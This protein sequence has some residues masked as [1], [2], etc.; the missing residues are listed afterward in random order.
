MCITIIYLS[1]MQVGK[2]YRS[3]NLFI[4]LLRRI[5]RHKVIKLL[6]IYIYMNKHIIPDNPITIGIQN[7]RN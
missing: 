5:M 7:E 2:K 4:P 6:Y 3:R 1:I